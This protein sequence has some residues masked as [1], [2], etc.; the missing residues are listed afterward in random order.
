M[1]Q[2]GTAG[3]SH[4]GTER[5]GH[6]DR[7]GGSDLSRPAEYLATT[8]DREQL[9]EFAVTTQEWLERTMDTLEIAEAELAEAREQIAAYQVRVDNDA[10]RLLECE[11]DM[12]CTMG[13]VEPGQ[14][15]DIRFKK[16]ER[17]SAH[18]VTADRFSRLREVL[19]SD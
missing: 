15:Y 17:N 16:I 4:E 9:I 2:T 14:D 7:Y 10:L 18:P 12:N 5:P 11:I 8:L 6:R 19:D 3:A 13:V 1:A